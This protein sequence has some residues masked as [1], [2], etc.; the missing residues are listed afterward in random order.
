MLR[1]ARGAD[2][3]E[4]LGARIV[5]LCG[6]G[7]AVYVSAVWRGAV[8]EGLWIAAD[9]RDEGRFEDVFKNGGR[10]M[11]LEFAQAEDLPAL[12]HFALAGD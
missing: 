3:F 4:A 7:A 8:V 12:A 10:E 5:I 1:V 9:M 6:G 11:V 2:D